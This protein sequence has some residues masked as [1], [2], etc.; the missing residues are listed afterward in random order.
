MSPFSLI[1]VVYT[2][3]IT[4]A[5]S[6]RNFKNG[7]RKSAF[8]GLEKMHCCVNERLKRIAF[9]ICAYVKLKNYSNSSI[10]VF[11]N[12]HAYKITGL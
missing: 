7:F 10:I 3:M 11:F 4:A 12:N 1:F 6:K 2:E 8:S 9:L 5:F